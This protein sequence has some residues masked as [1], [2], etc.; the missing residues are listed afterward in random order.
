MKKL[1]YILFLFFVFLPLTG[2]PDKL[3]DYWDECEKCVN[4]H[5]TLSNAIIKYQTD[6]N[7]LNF[8][9]RSEEDY[10]N[11]VKIAY[12]RKYIPEPFIGAQKECSYRYNPKDIE[13]HCIKHGSLEFVKKYENYKNSRKK[14]K[15]ENII[16]SLIGI[17]AVIFAIFYER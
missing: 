12:D 4:G 10:Q 17:F 8:T 6:S 15:N 3:E 14:Q 5:K 16:F 2:F 7:N 1:K 11:F 9:I 13:P